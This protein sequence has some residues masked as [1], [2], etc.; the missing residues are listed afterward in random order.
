MMLNYPWPKNLIVTVDEVNEKARVTVVFPRSFPFRDK[1]L[2]VIGDSVAAAHQ[3]AWAEFAFS[4]RCNHNFIPD[5]GGVEGAGICVKCLSRFDHIL[6]DPETL[7]RT[8]Q[9]LTVQDILNE[10]PDAPLS[11]A[12]YPTCHDPENTRRHLSD[13][14]LGCE[15]HETARFRPGSFQ[16]AFDAMHD[17]ADE[18][19]DDYTNE[20][21]LEAIAHVKELLKRKGTSFLGRVVLR[22]GLRQL[23]KAP[24]E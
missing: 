2:T 24:L 18:I 4:G 9:H 5:D 10:T 15:V 17:V 14:P 8:E 20:E 23:G 11:Y 3:I 19:D 13:Q 1:I 16:D 6:V 12:V 21:I 22:W 7:N